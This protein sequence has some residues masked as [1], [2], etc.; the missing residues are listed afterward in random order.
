MLEHT[1]PN[2]VISTGP[3]GTGK[4]MLPCQIGMTQVKTNKYDRVILTR[5]LVTIES[6]SIGYL[7]GDIVSKTTPWMSHMLD[8]CGSD[9]TPN[10]LQ[11][12]PLGFL[13][14]HTFHNTF[15]IADEMQNSTPNQMKTLLT[16]VGKN[17]KLVITGDLGQSDLDNEINGLQDLIEKIHDYKEYCIDPDI[18]NY[19]KTITFNHNDIMR[20]EFVKKIYDIYKI[21]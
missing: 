12:H 1:K 6:E 5:P 18:Y 7:P 21:Y 3:A 15:I 20:S 14:G 2:L 11:V 17:S 9:I 4:T 16:R 10:Q 13:R 8:Y 19:V